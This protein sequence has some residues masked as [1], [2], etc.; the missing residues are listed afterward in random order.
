M[1]SITKQTIAAS[2]M[3]VSAVVYAAPPKIMVLP[4]LTW[5]TQKGYGENQTNQG[6]TRFVP[7][8]DQCFV[9]PEMTNV[10]A[11]ISD[12]MQNYNFPLVNYQAQSAAD[13]DEDAIEE[14]YTSKKTGAEM[15]SSSF[16][17]ILNKAQPDILLKVGWDVHKV[18]F[19]YSISYR[20]D[21]VDSYSNKSIATVTGESQ[22]VP[23]STALSALLKA[24]AND[25][26]AEFTTKLQNHFDDLIANG[27]EMRINIR[28]TDGTDTDMDTEFNGETLATLIYN[29]MGENTVNGS[30]SERT[31]TPNRLAYD[32]VRVPIRDER[33]R[34][35][36]ARQFSEQLRKYLQS[37]CGIKIENRSSGLGVGRLYII[38]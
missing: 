31:S 13:D 29:W 25:K 14:A 35:I 27:R 38:E 5:A 10:N 2:L 16:D 7:N 18:G 26:M 34:N 3:A 22:V 32:Q 24:T 15:Q 4:D 20:M 33:G 21:A 1:I 23:S 36:Q 8:Y 19:N 28:T 17:D 9:D 37:T 11:A 12:L 6:R 30:F